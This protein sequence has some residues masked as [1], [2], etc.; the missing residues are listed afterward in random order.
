MTTTPTQEQ[1]RLDIG[2]MSCASCAA[3][4]EKKLNKLDGV[5]AEVNYATE[6]AV[7]DVPAGMDPQL[8]VQVVEKTGYTAVVHDPRAGRDAAL[9]DSGLHSPRSI[10][11]RLIVSAAL[12]V[13][14]VLVSMIPALQFDYWQWVMLALATPVVVWGAYPF[15]WS[16]VVNARHGAATM[17]TLISIGVTAAYV[18]SLWAMVFGH[19]GDPGMRMHWAWISQG[20]GM[21]EIY[22]EVA[23]AVTV[24][25][26]GGKFLEANAKARSSAALR[27]L[28]ELGAKQVTVLRDGREERIDVDL[29]G[30][31]DRFVVRPG[32]KI[33]TDGVVV[34]GRGAV[35]ESMLTGESVPVDVEPGDRVTGATVNRSGRLIVEAT[36]V[37]GDTQLA[38]MARLVE[39]AQEGK[40]DVQRLAD[41]VAGWFVPSVLVLAVATLIVWLVVD[42]V[43]TA[44]FSAAIAVLIIACPCALGLA[45]PTALMV[46]TGRGAQL[47]ILIRGPQVLESTR[48]ID[49]VVLDKTG[50]I[51]TG[52]MTVV[53]VDALGD[54][55]ALRRLAASVESAS[56]H[57]VAQ[58]IARLAEP[59][60]VKD[61]VNHEGFG[62]SG[63]VDGRHVIVGRP[64][65][66]GDQIGADVAAPDRLG[67]TVAVAADGELLGT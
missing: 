19:A 67:T 48:R 64:S 51:T 14:V 35:D 59:L 18:W 28:M 63:V 56:E 52:E 37:G 7:V 38:Q 43:S 47:G 1:Y 65:W 8:L 3:R 10:R 31:G 55:T 6:K 17:D 36:A 39:Q 49:T 16:A 24:F 34:E 27:S 26:L 21:H 15:H 23:S 11:R 25:I 12:S 33:A 5:H 30:V 61:F 29:L 13:P 66:V 42:G 62:V 45:T 32:E 60:A 22:L 54:D 2:G 57:P 46:G 44:A 53:S 40:A 58:A 41:R 9:D 4:I 50:T 20:D